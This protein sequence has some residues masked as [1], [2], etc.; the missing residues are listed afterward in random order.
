MSNLE[1]TLEES[2]LNYSAFVIQRRAIPD[3]RDGFKYTARQII[4]AQSKEKLDAA[5]PF[6]KSQKSVSAATAFSY[7]HGDTSAYEQIIRM[8]RPLVQRYFFEEINGNGGTPTGASTYSAPRYTEARL[9]PLAAN[10][11]NYIDKET[12]SDTDWSPTYDEAGYFPLVLPS[13]GFYNLCNGSFGSIGVGLISS[14]PQFNLKEM[15]EAI[16]K[17]IDNPNEDVYLMPDFASGGILLNPQTTLNSLAKGEGKSILLRSH[18]IKNEKEKYLE[19]IDL[20]YGIYTDTLCIELEKALNDNEAPYT[21]FKDLSKN[22]VKVRIYG[23]NLNEIEEWLY[24]NTCAQ[25]HFTIKMTMLDNGKTPKIFSIKEALLAHIKHSKNIFRKQYLYDLKKLAEREHIINGLIKAYSILD[26]IIA[27]IKQSSGRADSINKLR[28][29]YDFSAEQAAAIVDLKLHKLSSVDIQELRDELD[30]NLAEQAATKNILE[31]ENI[32]NANLK[33]VY[34]MVAKNYGDKRRTEI[35]DSDFYENADGEKPTKPF[36]FG[37]NGN[38]YAAS[39]TEDDEIL[40][41]YKPNIGKFQ[42]NTEYIFITNTLRGFCINTNDIILGKYEI[43]ELIKL[44]PNEKLIFMID[45]KSLSTHE[46]YTLTKSD[47]KQF[48]MHYSFLD[49]SSKRGKKLQNGNYDIKF[50]EL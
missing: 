35:A 33:D 49:V 23:N 12:L 1:Q 13:V 43:S 30:R 2:F 18:I 36:Y 29:N 50:I 34:Q 17:L 19:I 11:L 10:V 42:L 45:R 31:N 48:K 39:Y 9:S 16:C 4:H 38:S 5:H 32:F 47:G 21:S 26:E 14:I 25:R 3:A 6:K 46:F 27:L 7:V 37:M 8:G 24:K 44:K 20:P 22:T 40:S 28:V 15:N 41:M